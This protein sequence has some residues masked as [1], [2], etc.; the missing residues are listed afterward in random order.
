MITHYVYVWYVP[1][2]MHTELDMQTLLLLPDNI[3]KRKLS[4]LQIWRK[5]MAHFVSHAS[6]TKFALKGVDRII[7]L[8][9]CTYFQGFQSAMLWYTSYLRRVVMA[10]NNSTP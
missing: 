2:G 4:I 1:V 10:N 8:Q 9:T 3:D 6:A 5:L 7:K